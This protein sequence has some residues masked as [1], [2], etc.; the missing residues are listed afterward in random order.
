MMSKLLSI[1]PA[2]HG[3]ATGPT[4][5]MPEAAS[6]VAGD[7]DW[8]LEF[9]NVIS[10]IFF[11]IIVFALLY[12]AIKYRRDP[13]R[14]QISGEG[15]THGL[16]LELTWTII[17][18]LLV[19]VIFWVGMVGY[20]DL[21]ESPDDSYEVSVAAQKWSWTFTHPDYAVT[22][23]GELTVP[24]GRPVRL[25][26]TSADVLHSL[27]VP[28]FRVKQDIVPGRYSTLW[29]EA[30]KPGS[31]QLYCAEYCGRDHSTMLATVHVLPEEEF[32]ATMGKLAREYEDLPDADLP[33]YALTRLYNRCSS[34]HSLDGSTGTGP[35]FQGL[36]ERSTS[37]ST[38]FTD[39]TTLKDYMG[40][41]GE[42]Q[43]PEN[44]IRDSILN[45]GK[46]LVENYTNV[47]PNNFASQLKPRQ[48]EA[49]VLMM[50]HFDELV[51]EE[52]NI[53]EPPAAEESEASTGDGG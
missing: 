36:W 27:F 48:V 15:P 30:T 41:G 16:A 38:V 9:I 47:M 4:F 14:K 3:D 20:I 29:F 44:Y 7:V 18:T 13:E 5:W 35:S 34:C 45:P 53:I 25:V 32:Q 21:R 19:V 43:M 31:Y 37:G 51:D 11:V 24:L 50:K 39:G 2:A 52:G 33:R 12:L 26:M 17:P 46:N 28:A 49:L 10:Y 23:G 22:E 40:S 42:Y 6:S 1:F 8:I